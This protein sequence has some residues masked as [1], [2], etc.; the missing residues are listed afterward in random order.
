MIKSPFFYHSLSKK[1][2]TPVR[3]E[4]KNMYSE[5]HFYGITDKNPLQYHPGEPIHFHLEYCR[6]DERIPCEKI[7]WDMISDDGQKAEGMIENANGIADLTFTLSKGTLSLKAV[8]CGADGNPIPNAAPFTGGALVDWDRIADESR[9][10]AD[11]DRFWNEQI[12]LLDTVKPEILEM[13][14]VPSPAPD[15][16]RVYDMKIACV[17]PRPV[18]GY[19][20]IPNGDKSF[21]AKIT[22]MGYSKTG[23]SVPEAYDGILFQTNPHGI[24][25]GREKAYYTALENG[26]LRAFGFDFFGTHLNHDPYTVYF[27]FMLLRALQGTRFLKTLPQWNKKELLLEGGSMG[28]MQATFVAAHEPDATRVFVPVPWMCDLS[29]ILSGRFEGWRPALDIGIPYYDT[30]SFAKRVTQPTCVEAGLGDRVCPP[31]GVTVY[32]RNLKGPKQLVYFQGMAHQGWA[33]ENYMTPYPVDRGYQ[34]LHFSNQETDLMVVSQ[35]DIDS[36]SR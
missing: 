23:A 14:E 9:E 16:G 12:A 22:F 29:G 17:G 27:R 20:W 34:K 3:A 5:L 19:L 32:F 1:K 35:K 30:A 36:V 8:A 10:P 28:G 4:R 6:G 11:F 26:E 31:S 2:R 21:P 18:S 33:K 7:Q 24:E 15:R 25:N 13:R